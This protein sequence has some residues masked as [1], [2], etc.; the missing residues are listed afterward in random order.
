MPDLFPTHAGQVSCLT[1]YPRP[2]KSNVSD[3]DLLWG[4]GGVSRGFLLGGLF[5]LRVDNRTCVLRVLGRS[6]EP[7]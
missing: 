3:A 5:A 4:K 1:R 6:V 2:L 7:L